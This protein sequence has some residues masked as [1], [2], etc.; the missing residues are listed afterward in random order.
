MSALDSQPEIARK[1]AAIAHP[2]A[3]SLGLSRDA[4]IDV[5]GGT[6]S[7]KGVATS[8][9]TADRLRWI[10][11]FLDLADKAIAVV[12]C[13]QGLTY[14]PQRHLDAQRDH[15]AWARWLETRRH[16]LERPA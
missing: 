2:H 10:A 3:G 7:Q 11:D 15:R 5:Y 9:P 6:T 16:P 12:A 8:G 14:P 13:A 1:A 4:R